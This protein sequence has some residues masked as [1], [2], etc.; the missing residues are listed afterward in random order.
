MGKSLHARLSRYPGLSCRRAI[1]LAA[2]AMDMP[3]SLI[4]R[5]EYAFHVAICSACRRYS[6]QIRQL[7][8]LF[9]RFGTGVPGAGCRLSHHAAERMRTKLKE[10]SRELPPDGL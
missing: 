4:E 10:E 9:A 7:A 5:V 6:R 8:K 1:R 3:L 2:R